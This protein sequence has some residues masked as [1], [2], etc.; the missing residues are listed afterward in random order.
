MVQDFKLQQHFGHSVIVTNDAFGFRGVEDASML[1]EE[2]HGLLNSPVEL[3]SPQ[4]LTC[5]WREVP[6]YRWL[7]LLFGVDARDHFD[8]TSV[9]LQDF[10]I[11]LSNAQ[12]WDAKSEQWRANKTHIC[13]ACGY[14]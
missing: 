12:V 10:L 4:Y 8:V 7:S 3:S 1:L 5:H 11:F 13:S 6:G 2:L 9:V 14:S